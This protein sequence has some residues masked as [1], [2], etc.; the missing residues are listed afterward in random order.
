MRNHIQISDFTNV[1]LI[2]PLVDFIISDAVLAVG[3][4]ERLTRLHKELINK[5]WSMTLTSRLHC[6]Q[7]T[8]VGWLRRPWCMVGLGYR[9]MTAKA[10]FHLTVR[11]LSTMKISGNLNQSLLLWPRSIRP[12]SFHYFLIWEKKW[13]RLGNGHSAKVFFFLNFATPKG[14]RLHNLLS[15]QI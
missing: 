14:K 7:R 13:S 5:D 12:W 8:H 6:N 1:K 15:L 11:S 2:K 4:K 3:N 9:K 10:K